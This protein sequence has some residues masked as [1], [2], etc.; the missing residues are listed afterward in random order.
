MGLSSSSSSMTWKTSQSTFG[1]CDESGFT[2]SSKSG[3]VSCSTG[4]LKRLP[5]YGEH[6]ANN[7]I[8]QHQSCWSSHTTNAHLP[9]RKDLGTI[10]WRTEWNT[11]T[12]GNPIMGCTGDDT[13]V[14]LCMDK[15]QE[16]FYVWISKHY[17]SHLPPTYSQS[18]CRWPLPLH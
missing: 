12:V 11:H 14:V 6:A 17:L 16:L 2:L 4:G 1:N 3:K 9:R 5:H 8:V 10:L 13:G 7:Q 18:A 15:Q